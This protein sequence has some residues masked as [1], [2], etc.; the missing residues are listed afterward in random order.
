MCVYNI[1]FIYSSIKGY[2][3]CFHLCCEQCS[4]EHGCAKISV[5]P[6]NSFGYKP[7]NG[8]AESY[9]S[10]IF[11]F[12]KKTIVFHS[13]CTVLHSNQQCN[14]NFTFQLTVSISLQPHKHLLFSIFLIVASLMGI[15]LLYLICFFF[16]S[17][18]FYNYVKY[19]I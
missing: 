10:S 8:I 18:W 19:F 5:T 3:G 13:S 15:R 6:F 14:F 12:L 16:H 1:L 4:Y 2:L 7:W 11:N 17:N 9:G